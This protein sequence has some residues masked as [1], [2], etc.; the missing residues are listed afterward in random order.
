[1]KLITWRH[2]RKKQVTTAVQVNWI[3]T[4]MPP[5]GFGSP[6]QEGEKKPSPTESVKHNSGGGGKEKGAAIDA[7]ASA[8]GEKS[9]P[10][11]TGGSGQMGGSIKDG[12]GEEGDIQK[13]SKRGGRAVGG[14]EQKKP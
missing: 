6:D 10:A 3:S 11:E 8:V 5:G 7:P 2:R 14:R 4:P 1:M 9:Y 12:W 13:N